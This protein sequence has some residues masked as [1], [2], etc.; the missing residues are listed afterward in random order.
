MIDGSN[1]YFKLKDLKLN[2]QLNF[3][4]RAFGQFLAGSDKI[5]DACYYVGR[6]KQDGTKRTEELFASQQ[7]LMALLKKSG[8]RYSLGYLM[9]N[10]GKY[11]EKGV[12]VQIATDLL[13]AAYENQCDKI[14]LVSSDTDL[15]PAIKKAR[16]KGKQVE[17]IGFSHQPS[18]AMVSFCS[19]TRLLTEED[20]RGLMLITG[21]VLDESLKTV[22]V[23]IRV[24]KKEKWLVTNATKSQS[25]QWT[26]LHFEGSEKKA[27]EIVESFSQSLKPGPWYTN[28]TTS[29]GLVFVIFA[30]KFFNYQKGDGKVRKTAAQYGKSVGIP[31]DQLDWKE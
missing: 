16:Q 23:T 19:T 29:T 26:A 25:N 31:K 1:F 18:V 27:K 22:P 28:F 14:I 15:A 11:H 4:F 20:V 10:D 5:V 24:V 9:K 21:I 6:I 30:N 3:D 17:Y 13:V 2:K 7:R 8:F 12:D